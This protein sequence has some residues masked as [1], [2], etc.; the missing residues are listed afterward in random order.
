MNLTYIKSLDGLRGIAVILV[1]LFH[2][3]KVPFITLGFEIGWIGVQL[4]FVL[5]GFLITR[6]LV[7]DKE[8]TFNKYIKK[9]YWRRSL[10]I[11]PLY[12]A[13][14]TIVAGLYVLTGEPQSYQEAAPFLFTYTANF[15]IFSENY[16]VS[17][18]FT[19]L[20]S[21]SVEEQ[22]YLIWPF[23]IFFMSIRLF[24]RF[25]VLLI[26]VVPIIRY[27]LGVVFLQ[28]FG[29]EDLAGNAV[30]FMTLSHFDA[31]AM[32]G[33]VFLLRDNYKDWLSK[34][35]W[36]LIVVFFMLGVMNL[37]SQDIWNVE[38]LSSLGYEIRSML[39]YQHVWSYTLINIICAI[40]ILRLNRKEN[41]ILMNPVLVYLGKISYGMYVYHMLLIGIFASV[42][43][44]VIIN[45][46][47]SLFIIFAAILL[48]SSLSYYIF[49]KRFLNLK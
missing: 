26:I 23:I 2:F 5:S 27:F 18:F 45:D 48:I 9:F 31:F 12:F 35:L 17:R 49:E 21:L 4:F 42:I 44:K 25:S 34:M 6:I 47:I 24:K 1:I 38:I 16:E 15:Y 10:R 7:A 32:G 22:F 11:F 19:H 46:Y 20:W 3:C 43:G 36:P 28:Y 40:I 41:V 37:L 33:L 13:Y 39:N 14:L 8:S 30:Y 29:S